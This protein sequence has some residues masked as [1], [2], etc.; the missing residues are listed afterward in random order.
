MLISPTLSVGRH[1]TRAALV[2]VKVR[3]ACVGHD[4]GSATAAK[5]E[6]LYGLR[7]QQANLKDVLNK[8]FLQTFLDEK[9][10]LS[11]R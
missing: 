9:M 1:S 6:S 11:C 2:S 8:H 3:E 10:S 7:I 5:R 4:G